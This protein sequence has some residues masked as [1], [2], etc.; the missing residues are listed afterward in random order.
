MMERDVPNDGEGLSVESDGND[1]D[2]RNVELQFWQFKQ[3]LYRA[4]QVAVRQMQAANIRDYI[5]FGR[6]HI[7]DLQR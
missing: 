2:A 7:G 1:G 4:L 5:S 3:S 6:S